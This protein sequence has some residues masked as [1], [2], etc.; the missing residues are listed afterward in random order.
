MNRFAITFLQDLVFL[1]V[2]MVSVSLLLTGLAYSSAVSIYDEEQRLLNEDAWAL[3]DYLLSLD[4]IT[5]GGGRGIFEATKLDEVTS[6]ILE[7]GLMKGHG[8]RLTIQTIRL[9]NGHD[10]RSWLW[11]NGP[12]GNDLG[13][14]Q[15]SAAVDFGQ[16]HVVPVKVVLWVWRN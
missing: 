7:E 1:A 3:C 6:D 12:P 16:A 14:C 8:Y 9:S 4:A 13:V 15:T 2:A 10:Q 5:V 11:S